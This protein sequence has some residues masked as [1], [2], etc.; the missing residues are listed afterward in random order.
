MQMEEI[1][2]VIRM[3]TPTEMKTREMIMVMVTES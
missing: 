1:I 2:Q 3:E